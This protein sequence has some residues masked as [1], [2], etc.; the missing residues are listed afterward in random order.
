MKIL[1]IVSQF[2]SDNKLNTVV[3]KLSTYLNKLMK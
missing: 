2:I 1:D 3:K